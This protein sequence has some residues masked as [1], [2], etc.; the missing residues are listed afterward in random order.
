MKSMLPSTVGKRED[1]GYSGISIFFSCKCL[2]YQVQ[3]K[4]FNAIPPTNS[5]SNMHKKIGKHSCC[6]SRS[7]FPLLNRYIKESLFIRVSPFHHFITAHLAEVLGHKLKNRSFHCF[8]H[9]INYTS[10]ENR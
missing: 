9:L 10:T 1:M 8:K 3:S 4:S 2:L 6:I 7:H 5:Y